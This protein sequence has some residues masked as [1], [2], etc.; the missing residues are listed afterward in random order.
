MMKIILSPMGTTGD[1]RPFISL[2]LA[3]EKLGNIVTIVAPQNAESMCKEFGL[4]YIILDFDY[5]EFVSIINNKPSLKKM[6]EL[7]DREISSPFKVL[8]EIARH[9]DC[10]IGSARNY[11]L[12]P[13]A[14]LYQLP[15]FQVWHTPQVFE[16][17]H[18]TPWRFL[19]QD[20]PAW[21][22]FIYWKLHNMKENNI[23]KRFV[24][25]HRKYMGLQ[26]IKNY[27]A[28]FKENILFVADNTLAPV[29][30]DVKANY[31]QT[32]YWHLYESDELDTKLNEFISKGSPPVFFSFG[33][34]PDSD[35]EQTVD[36][37]ENIVKSLNMRAIIQ[38]G[39]AGLEQKVASKRILVIDA[40]PHYK[41]FPYMA[42]VIHH[43]GA[44]TVHTAALAG[45]PQV[46]IPQYGDQFYWG[47]RVKK[48]QIGPSPIPKSMLNVENL[49]QAIIQAVQDKEI[50]DSAKRM[51]QILKQRKG[52]DEIALKI[53]DILLERT[54]RKS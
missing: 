34:M 15:Y 28:L 50:I 36:I 14:E 29:P 43:G 51:A 1:I 19:S 7:L 12:Q 3:L 4:N 17:L 21:K 47:D 5:R 9:A 22:N 53:N 20:N 18:L 49:T 10:I 41:L 25:K 24:N 33:S 30:A 52:I 2:S 13:I 11:M 8:K 26:P 27:A 46:I 45:I 31:L 16:S 42:T 35:G 32:D 6:I 44:G 54:N 23:G 37:I 38:K 40:T 39:W 48:L